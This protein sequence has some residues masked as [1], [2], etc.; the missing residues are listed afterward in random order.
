MAWHELVTGWPET[1]IATM[2]MAVAVVT[3]QKQDS[4]K[5][6]TLEEMNQHEPDY[7]IA[8]LHGTNMV[9]TWYQHGTNMVSV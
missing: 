3:W 2:S 7:R 5:T 4:N 8:M 1:Q 6:K 9:P